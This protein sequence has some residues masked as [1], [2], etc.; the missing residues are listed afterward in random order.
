MK[1][2][3]IPFDIE[4]AK[5]IQAGEI[6][7]KIKYSEY[8]GQ[9]CDAEIIK[10]DV[11]ADKSRA[12]PNSTLF[13]T[14]VAIIDFDNYQGVRTFNSDGYGCNH[15]GDDTRLFLEVQEEAPKHLTLDDCQ[16][17]DKVWVKHKDNYILVKIKDK[18]PNGLIYVSNLMSNSEELYFA[19]STRAY[20]QKPKFKP[21]D[22][23]LV[24]DNCD[25]SSWKPSLFVKYYPCAM[26]GEEYF[27][28]IGEHFYELCIPYEG[29]EH[30]VGTTDNPKED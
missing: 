5:K 9:A 17:G 11:I 10:F 27:E 25:M 15:N 29:N 21:F 14:I 7:G 13:R 19:E 22:K 12:K 23:V 16:V 4:L 28:T 20:R 26:D 1:I 30:L 18:N 2:K 24:R 8:D 3:I 6:K